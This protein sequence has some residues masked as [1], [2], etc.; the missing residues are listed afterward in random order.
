MTPK[1]TMEDVVVGDQLRIAKT[2]KKATHWCVL[3]CSPQRSMPFDMVCLLKRYAW[4]MLELIVVLPHAGLTRTSLHALATSSY[5]TCDMLMR[6][7]RA[8]H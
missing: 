4:S 5:W 6:P 2:C 1:A 8:T 7:S 3:L